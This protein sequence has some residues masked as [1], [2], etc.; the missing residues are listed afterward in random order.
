M[1][2]MVT[3]DR[4]EGWPRET[5]EVEVLRIVRDEMQLDESFTATSSLEAA[6]LDSLTLVR[7]LVEIDEFVGVWLEGDELTPQTL[8]TVTH[9]VDA[10]CDRM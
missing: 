2:D 3:Q 8:Q 7:I 5:L 1:A 9:I 6:G 10:I 4:S